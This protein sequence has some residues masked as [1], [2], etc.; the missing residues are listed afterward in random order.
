MQVGDCLERVCEES[1]V[2][3]PFDFVM[4]VYLRSYF[5]GSG[6]EDSGA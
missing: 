3:Q 5:V 2:V 6:V 1:V 4:C